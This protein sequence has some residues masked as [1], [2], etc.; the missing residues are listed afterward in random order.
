MW[1]RFKQKNED[2]NDDGND[3][4]VNIDDVGDG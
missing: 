2:D 4:I 1:L 3:V